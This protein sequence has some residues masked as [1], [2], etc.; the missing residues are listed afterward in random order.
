MANGNPDHAPGGKERRLNVCAAEFAS[1]AAADTAHAQAI[2]KLS[3]T[4]TEAATDRKNDHKALV[5]KLDGFM[6]AH[7]N[8]VTAVEGSAKAAHHRINWLF[9]LLSAAL[10]AMGGWAVATAKAAATAITGGAG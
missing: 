1:L 9:G 3:D 10:L 5:K 8:R 4:I 7:E 2:D 6:L